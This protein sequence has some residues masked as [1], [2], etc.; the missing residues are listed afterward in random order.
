MEGGLTFCAENK[1]RRVINLFAM[2]GFEESVARAR[3]FG[4]SRSRIDL[5][6]SLTPFRRPAR[7]DRF[8]NPHQLSGAHQS[9]SVILLWGRNV[10]ETELLLNSDLYS[11]SGVQCTFFS[12]LSS[13]REDRERD[14]NVSA[15]HSRSRATRVNLSFRVSNANSINTWIHCRKFISRI[16]QS[17]KTI[18]F[19]RSSEQKKVYR[20]WRHFDSRK[21]MNRGTVPCLF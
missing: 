7:R 5:N 20:T 14:I 1:A 2:R 11:H 10:V 18:D 15:I 8:I 16:E 17:E 21:V 4:A 6:A 12:S 9:S 13:S 19:L 3:K